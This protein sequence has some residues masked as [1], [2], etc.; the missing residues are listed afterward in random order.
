MQFE[1]SLLS[2]LPVSR[3]ICIQD[4]QATYVVIV[5]CLFWPCNCCRGAAHTLG[6]AQ[7]ARKRV[8]FVNAFVGPKVT[9]SAAVQIV[10]DPHFC[11]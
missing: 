10:S 8:H 11:L 3:Q 6:P 5:T 2:F 1:S 7:T 4:K 9:A